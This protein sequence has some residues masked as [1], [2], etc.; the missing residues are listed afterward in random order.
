M[1]AAYAKGHADAAHS[2]FQAREATRETQL[3]L[4]PCTQDAAENAVRELLFGFPLVDDLGV[5]LALVVALAREGAELFVRVTQRVG[6]ILR[7]LLVAILELSQ[8]QGFLGHRRI[9]CSDRRLI[10]VLVQHQCWVDK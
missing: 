4:T 5:G 8:G 1:L 3:G 10:L 9:G 2:P 7:C 6:E